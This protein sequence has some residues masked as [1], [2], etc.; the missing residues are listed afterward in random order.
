LAEDFRSSTHTRQYGTEEGRPDFAITVDHSDGKRESIILLELKVGDAISK[1]QGRRYLKLLERLNVDAPVA[2]LVVLAPEWNRTT[3]EEPSEAPEHAVKRLSFRDLTHAAERLAVSEEDVALWRFLE[4]TAEG[5]QTAMPPLG[6]ATVLSDAGVIQE[7]YEW[8]TLFR[9]LG[10]HLPPTSWK[11]G[12]VTR[13]LLNILETEYALQHQR[14]D[15]G[16]RIDFGESAA[17]ADDNRGQRTPIWFHFRG[18]KGSEESRWLSTRLGRGAHPDELMKRFSHFGD[19]RE[20]SV[21]HQFKGAGASDQFEAA[22]KILW[23]A[24]QASSMAAWEYGLKKR[25]QISDETGFGLRMRGPRSSKAVAVS[26][27]IGDSGLRIRIDENLVQP[28][29]GESSG[30]HYVNRVVSATKSAIESAR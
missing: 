14:S 17:H 29:P 3:F 12:F 7:M 22:R 19:D 28:S 9:S 30:R 27:A 2:L 13:P 15:R 16:W 21:P 25:E 11:T 20:Q 5:M 18:K 10:P 4:V 6:D 23:T 26:I 24:M 8:V 1:D